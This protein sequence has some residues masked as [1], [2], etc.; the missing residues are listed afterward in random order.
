[1]ALRWS[2]L[3]ESLQGRV[4]SSCGGAAVLGAALE[5]TSRAKATIASSISPAVELGVLLEREF[6][7]SYRLM[8]EYRFLPGRRYRIDY[9]FPDQKVA[10]EFDGYRSHG[11]SLEGFR[12]GL[13]RQNLLVLEGWRVLR[14]T[15]TDLREPAR[16]LIEIQTLLA[17]S[18]RLS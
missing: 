11:I 9:A 5:Q 18:V 10:I 12:E 15:V 7:G 16:I 4:K 13:R 6:S 3:P 8:P 1:M 14:Y 2:E 17:V